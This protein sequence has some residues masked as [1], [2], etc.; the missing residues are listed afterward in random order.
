ML[1]LK[2]GVYTLA[3]NGQLFADCTTA[4]RNGTSGQPIR[5]AAL[6]ERRAVVRTG[7][8]EPA[9]LI[10]GCSFWS[11]EGLT[12]ENQDNAA[13]TSPYARFNSDDAGSNRPELVVTP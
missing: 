11:V 4:T 1:I 3:V 2:D 12:L 9:M 10:R 5:V 13:A 7:G 8:L 6:N